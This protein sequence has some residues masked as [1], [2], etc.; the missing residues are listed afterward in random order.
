MLRNHA[1]LI[2][3]CGGNELYPAAVSPPRDIEASLASLTRDLDGTRPYIPSSMS[4]YTNYDPSFALAPKDGPYGQLELSEFYERNP[5]L[6]FWNKT[7]ADR[8]KIAFQ[9][10][11]GSISTPVF[12]SMRQFMSKERLEAFPGSNMSR[13]GNNEVGL[14]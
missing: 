13:R 6:R 8:L 5:G 1:S 4:N 11:I 3:W 2:F 7:R 14:T 10:E 9:P 12:E